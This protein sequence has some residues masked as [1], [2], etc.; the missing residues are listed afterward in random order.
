MRRTAVVL[1][2]AVAASSAAAAPSPVL[3]LDLM[4]QTLGG[5]PIL[6]Q[7][8]RAVIAT[9]GQP[10]RRIQ[11]RKRATF[12]Y[13]R[14]RASAG[15]WSAIVLFRQEAGSLRSSSVALSDRRLREATLGA[16]LQLPP[17]RLQHRLVADLG[18]RIVRSYRCATT[19]RGDAAIPGSRVR[20]GFGRVGARPPYLVLYEAD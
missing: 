10:A 17:R 15:S 2:A 4:A 16:P 14:L 12:F 3:R 5:K 13:G 20:V 9:L 11:G 1:I 19:C 18:M 7:T 6:G 8:T